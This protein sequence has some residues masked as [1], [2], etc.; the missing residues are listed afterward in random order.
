MY[1]YRP[2]Y[3]F[4][5]N[6]R[7]KSSSFFDL[8]NISYEPFIIGLAAIGAVLSFV[9]FQAIQNQGRRKK[10]SSDSDISLLSQLPNLD[11]LTF[12]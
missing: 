1:F 11:Y 3:L 2:A 4:S 7:V 5:N 8:I 9:L 6:N 12:K 10:R